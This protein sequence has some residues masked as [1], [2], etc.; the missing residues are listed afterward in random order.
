[1]HS[2]SK[3]IQE[4]SK[5]EI[6]KKLDGMGD[7][8]KMSYLQ[9]ALASRLDYDTKKF[10]LLR[11]AGIYEAR[12]MFLEAAKMARSAAEINTTFKEKIQDF[13][14]VVE[15]YIKGGEY[16]EA[17]RLFAQALALGSTQ[18][19][20]EMKTNFRN[21]YIMQGKFFLSN[22]K[23]NYARL[24]FE[25]C[26][27]LELDLSQKKEIQK[28]LLGLYDKLGLVKEYYALKGSL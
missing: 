8:V 10:V 23:R 22:D 15:L 24:A 12:R 4:K 19:K 25:K 27:T 9:R 3:P 5:G 26:L 18:E 20:F 14:K 17:D 28:Y 7:Y 11:L 2:V 16:D 1:M 21:Y 6:E 13:M